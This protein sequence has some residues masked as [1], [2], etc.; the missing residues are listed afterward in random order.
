MR[1]GWIVFLCGLAASP[2]ALLAGESAPRRDRIDAT[3]PIQALDMEELSKL[4]SIRDLESMLAIQ[5]GLR[6]STPSGVSIRGLVQT[7]YGLNVRGD[8][9]IGDDDITLGFSNPSVQFTVA[10]PVVENIEVLMSAGTTL[11]GNGQLTMRDALIN[12]KT[13]SNSSLQLGQFRP[14]YRREDKYHESSLNF[15]GYSVSSEFFGTRYQQGL[16]LAY[17]S[18]KLMLALTLTDGPDTSDTAFND[19]SE[20]DY[21]IGGR[22]EYKPYGDWAQ[23][24]DVTSFRGSNNALTFGLGGYFASEGDTNPASMTTNRQ[25]GLSADATYESDGWHAGATFDW[26]REEATG[27]PDVDLLGWALFGGIFLSDQI[28][29][30]A[31]IEQILADDDLALSVDSFLFAGVAL[32]YYFIPESHAAKIILD[33]QIAFD[34]T[35]SMSGLGATSWGPVGPT[36][37]TGFQ[38]SSE[39][40]QILMRLFIQGTF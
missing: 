13:S 19:P 27:A 25:C 12:I 36:S 29:L 1:N 26:Y 20:F 14:D 32:N 9:T 30:A 17:R 2:A 16:R 34:E 33:T 37:A 10:A 4:P 5:P 40:S 7:Q 24:I 38:L 11:Y 15:A 35:A 31:R 22:I 8:D 23:G 6:P 3:T 18:A 39:D 21:N 28:E